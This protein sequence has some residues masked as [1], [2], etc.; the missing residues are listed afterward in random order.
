MVH[1]H[2]RVIRLPVE[3]ESLARC[4]RLVIHVPGC[5]G[6]VE[7]NGMRH[8][9]IIGQREMDCL[10]LAHAQNGSRHRAI[11]SPGMVRGNGDQRLFGDQGE[12]N[13]IALRRHRRLGV[14]GLMRRHLHLLHLIGGRCGAGFSWC[15]QRRDNH[16]DDQR[17]GDDN[18]RASQI[19]PSGQPAPAGIS[20]VRVARAN[21]SGFPPWPLRRLIG[22]SKW[23]GLLVWGF[24]EF[25]THVMM[26]PSKHLV[27][28]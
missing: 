20:N 22:W 25:F 17:N 11:E 12:V 24:Q 21:L 28:M 26:L 16:S 23:R 13:T 7:I 5:L 14:I 2:A 9:A 18:A 3:G 8:T 4:H 15:A 10:S 27:C 1:K 19:A 6:R